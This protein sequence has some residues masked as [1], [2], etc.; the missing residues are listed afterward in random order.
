MFHTIQDDMAAHLPSQVDTSHLYMQLT[1]LGDVTNEKGLGTGADMADF[2]CGGV[3]V[4]STNP[5]TAEKGRKV[6]GT[7][8]LPSCFCHLLRD[9]MSHTLAVKKWLRRTTTQKIKLL[10]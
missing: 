10:M 9:A 1:L 4:A 5:G 7:W 3:G 2:F 8:F 6:Y